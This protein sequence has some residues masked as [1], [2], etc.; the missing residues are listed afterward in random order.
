MET[1]GSVAEREA[2]F[3]AMR[4]WRRLR[5]VERARTLLDKFLAKQDEWL[6]SECNRLGVGHLE[7]ED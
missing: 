3:I 5:N 2:L 7:Y 6:I 1:S 4:E